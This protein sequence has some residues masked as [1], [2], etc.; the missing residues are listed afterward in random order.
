MWRKKCWTSSTLQTSDQSF[1]TKPSVSIY[2]SLLSNWINVWVLLIGVMIPPGTK[3]SNRSS[4]SRRLLIP[5][6][7]SLGVFYVNKWLTIS[8]ILYTQQR[9]VL[10]KI[11]QWKIMSGRRWRCW[12]LLSDFKPVKPCTDCASVLTMASK[13]SKLQCFS[14]CLSVLSCV[15]RRE[16][17]SLVKRP[18]SLLSLARCTA[19]IIITGL[20]DTK[21]CPFISDCASPSLFRWNY[22]FILLCHKITAWWRLAVFF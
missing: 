22:P 1:H 19:A 9:S 13:L 7:T 8:N 20:S 6:W 5:L 17:V 4:N 2:H 21:L 16:P 3:K 12:V 11:R 10:K 18:F 15:V 14:V